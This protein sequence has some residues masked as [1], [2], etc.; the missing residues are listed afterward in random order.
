MENYPIIDVKTT[1]SY[2][3]ITTSSEDGLSG[4]TYQ[5][6][7]FSSTGIRLQMTIDTFSSWTRKTKRHKCVN[8]KF[9]DRHHRRNSNLELKDVVVPAEIKELAIN[10][11]IDFIKENIEINF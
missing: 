11:C 3:L 2:V 5:F 4:N 7:M 1:V 9:F 10:A 8:S 6:A